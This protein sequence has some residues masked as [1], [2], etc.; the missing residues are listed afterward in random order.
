[1]LYQ[2]CIAWLL[3]VYMPV[4]LA[5][6][7]PQI[8]Y[9]SR[10]TF[11]RTAFQQEAPKRGILR[12]SPQLRKQLA[13]ILGH[14]YAGRRVR[15]WYSE[16]RTAWIFDEIGKELPI[17]IG[18]VVDQGAIERLRILVYREE[19]G[20]EVHQA[21]F[22]R[23]FNQAKLTGNLQLNQ[24]IDGITGATLSVNAV[25]RVAR[26]ALLLDRILHNT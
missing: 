7:I 25:S 9:L 8:E 16:E 4:A 22:T 15:Y 13:T 1:M 3:C 17:T 23:Q 11:I 24:S 10:D 21:F 6:G 5:A 19:R 26:V 12:L 20:G 2:S 14:D 18:V